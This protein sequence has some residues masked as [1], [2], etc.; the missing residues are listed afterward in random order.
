MY[1]FT[2]ILPLLHHEFVF[3]KSLFK[4]LL[5]KLQSHFSSFF[6]FK[7]ACTHIL[8]LLHQEGLADV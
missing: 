4:L 3:A 2:H 7:I 8:Q 6:L 1:T 5:Q